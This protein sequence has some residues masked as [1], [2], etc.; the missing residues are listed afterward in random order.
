MTLSKFIVLCIC[1]MLFA[2][3]SPIILT[4]NNNFLADNTID[5]ELSTGERFN[6]LIARARIL[7]FD[8]LPIGECIGKIGESLIAIPY[9]GGTLEKD[10][11]QCSVDLSGLD[12]FTFFETSLN[13]SRLLKIENNRQYQDKDSLFPRLLEYITFTRYRDGELDGYLSRLHYMSEWIINNVKKGVIKDMTKSLGGK[14]FNLHVG[15]MSA[16]PQYYPALTKDPTLIP[17]IAEIEHR[18]NAEE[19][20]FI[21]TEQVKSIEDRLQTGDI[22]AIATNK[23]GLDYSHTG[24]IFK[25]EKGRA[26]FIH[27]SSTKK[28]V[29]KDRRISMFLSGNASS[30]GISV[31]RPLEPM[32]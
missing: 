7:G 27:A 6:Q 9:L 19:H 4:N 26:L 23:T 10:P 24:M 5:N 17:K 8:T 28:R 13:V 25:D 29:Y 14:K 12:C 11:E 30:I 32:K 21:P 3:F 22:I 16:N 15:F 2:G 31:L 20:W 18:I 1:I